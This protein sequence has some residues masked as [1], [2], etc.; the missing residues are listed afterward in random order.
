MIKFHRTG[1][2]GE[3]DTSIVDLGMDAQIFVVVAL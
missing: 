3:K 2:S 1:L